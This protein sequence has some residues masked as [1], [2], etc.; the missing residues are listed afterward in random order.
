MPLQDSDKILTEEDKFKI[1]DIIERLKKEDDREKVF[2]KPVDIE[3]LKLQDYLK[4]ISKPMDLGTV[5]KNLELGV[6]LKVSHALDDIQL[7][8][9]NCKKYN[10]EGS[11]N[12]FKEKNFI[13]KYNCIIF[14]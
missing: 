14:Y 4:I 10:Q 5:L 3:G 8:W 2:H 6:Y 12:I 13:N 1:K 7:I 9:D 11:V